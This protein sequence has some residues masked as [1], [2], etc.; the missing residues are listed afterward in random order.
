MSKNHNFQD[1][2][3]SHECSLL[4]D[5][6][7]LGN[8]K[9]F[10]IGAADSRRESIALDDQL[11]L[12]NSRKNSNIFDSRRNSMHHD[13][14]NFSNFGFNEENN[15]DSKKKDSFNGDLLFEQDKNNSFMNIENK[16]KK[17]EFSFDTLEKK[18]QTFNENIGLENQSILKDLNG[19]F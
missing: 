17:N 14:F 16:N 6:M 19:I 5:S 4:N 1:L 18:D 10:N 3:P 13:N 11:G 9:L 12:F 2:I 8:S 7:N 15:H